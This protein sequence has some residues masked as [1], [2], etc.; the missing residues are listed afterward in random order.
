MS[1][2]GGEADIPPQSRDFGFLSEADIY[3]FSQIG[4]LLADLPAVSKLL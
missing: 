3:L 4:M 1:A 2:F